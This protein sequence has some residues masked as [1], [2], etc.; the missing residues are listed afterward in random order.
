VKSLA[1]PIPVWNSGRIV[2][3]LVSRQLSEEQRWSQRSQVACMEEVSSKPEVPR[4]APVP[5]PRTKF[6]VRLAPEVAPRNGVSSEVMEAETTLP[7]PLYRSSAGSRGRG[8]MYLADRC[9]MENWRTGRMM[10]EV[11]GSDRQEVGVQAELDVEGTLRRCTPVEN[12]LEMG[13][14]VFQDTITSMVVCEAVVVEEVDGLELPT[15]VAP[16]T[17]V[18]EEF[19]IVEEPEGL[20]CSDTAVEQVIETGP[21]VLCCRKSGPEMAV[22]VVPEVDAMDTEQSEVQPKRPLKRRAED[23]VDAVVMAMEAIIEEEEVELEREKSPERQASA[24]ITPLAPAESSPSPPIEKRSTFSMTEAVE[25]AAP[26]P[27]RRYRPPKVVKGH[28]RRAIGQIGSPKPPPRAARV[29][30]AR[31]APPPAR[32]E[33]VKLAPERPLKPPEGFGKIGPPSAKVRKKPPLKPPEDFKW[34][35]RKY[36]LRRRAGTPGVPGFRDESEVKRPW[37]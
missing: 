36:N 14:E 33:E 18:A 6:G 2:S 30:R 5:A 20:E 8:Q 15:V 28:L 21:E 32:D 31:P 35:A 27:K 26:L 29:T 16:A 7:S 12:V 23:S 4:E 22:T 25:K 13:E 1:P 11:Q 24:E 9:V 10:T 17:A 37:R 3:K 34:A 19:V